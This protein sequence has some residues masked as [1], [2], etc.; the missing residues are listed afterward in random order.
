MVKKKEGDL[1]REM[2]TF[3]LIDSSL[4]AL[5]PFDTAASSGLA[6]VMALHWSSVIAAP[7]AA[8]GFGA[9]PIP[10]WEA[11]E[12]FLFCPSS[13]ATVSGALLTAVTTASAR[14]SLVG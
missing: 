3:G 12:N 8:T 7:C 6:W 10:L 5:S 13:P 4:D 11:S 2:R 9:S 1:H 14:T